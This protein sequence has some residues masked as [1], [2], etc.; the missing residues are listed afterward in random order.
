MPG[1]K[2]KQVPL[3]DDMV[4]FNNMYNSTGNKVNWGLLM[5]WDN[6]QLR[7]SFIGLGTTQRPCYEQ[8]D[9]FVGS[10]ESIRLCCT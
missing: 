6:C 5:C 4:H 3:P 1:I 10:N 9:S 7:G 8:R 2:D